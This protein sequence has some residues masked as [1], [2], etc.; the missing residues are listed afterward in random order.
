[1]DETG[2]AAF[3]RQNKKDAKTIQA[4]TAAVQRFEASLA[5]QGKTLATATPEDIRQAT[6]GHL[7]L[8]MYYEF[9]GDDRL[10]AAAHEAFAAPYSVQYAGGW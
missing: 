1:M 6:G 2:F 7:A 5:E 3:L 8:G 4:Y 10:C 9:L